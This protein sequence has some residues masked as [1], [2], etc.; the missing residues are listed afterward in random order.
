MRC[1]EAALLTVIHP[2]SA[3]NHPNHLKSTQIKQQSNASQLSNGFTTPPSPSSTST[4][5]IPA[6]DTNSARNG[7]GGFKNTLL[8]PGW[9][10]VI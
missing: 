9:A 2:H 1:D 6:L 10:V 4:S 7:A 5:P 3:L 8:S